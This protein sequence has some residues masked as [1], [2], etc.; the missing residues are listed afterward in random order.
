MESPRDI[1]LL[2]DFNAYAKVLEILESAKLATKNIDT[3]G[4]IEE[5]IKDTKS[6]QSQVALEL[7][8]E[9]NIIN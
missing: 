5:K 7:L 8:V 1:K 9:K 3:L 6:L 2:C 4:D